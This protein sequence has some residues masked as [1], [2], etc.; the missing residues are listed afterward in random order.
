MAWRWSGGPAVLM[1]R[2]IDDT[3]AI[4]PTRASFIAERGE[5]ANYH[6][7][8]IQAWSVAPNGEVSNVYA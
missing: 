4:Q 6:N 1:S 7:N 5:R 2:A 8:S 3:G